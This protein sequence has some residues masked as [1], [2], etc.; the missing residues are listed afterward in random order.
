MESYCKTLVQVVLAATALLLGPLATATPFSATSV[1]TISPCPSFCGGTGGQSKF[2]ID[3][4]L[5]G[6]LTSISSLDVTDGNGQAQ[7]T[8][9][10]TSLLPELSAEAFSN[11]GFRSSRVES[12]ATGMQ[13]YSYSGATNDITLSAVI[14]D[15]ASGEATIRGDIAV[16]I[17]ANGE[18]VPITTRLGDLIFEIIPGTNNLDLLGSD[19]EFLLVSGALETVSLD[20]NFTVNNGDSIFVW[21]QLLARGI[22]GGTADAFNTM[23]LSFSDPTGF[24]PVLGG[25]SV[26]VPEPSTLGLLAAGLV[27]LIMRRK[28]VA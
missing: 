21:S 4:G 22:R 28:R 10:G 20:V 11:S 7:A 2:D 8:F 26:Q 5:G 15:A 6:E 9:V 27:G 24:A 25:D 3:G 16:I 23:S 13:Q 1:S 18:D 17:A 14:D 12:N 19:F